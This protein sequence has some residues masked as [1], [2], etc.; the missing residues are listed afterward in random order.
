[1]SVPRKVEFKSLKNRGQYL[2]FTL[3][4]HLDQ[5]LYHATCMGWMAK[6]KPTYYIGFVTRNNFGLEIVEDIK[7]NIAMKDISLKFDNAKLEA[8]VMNK[9]QEELGENRFVSRRFGQASV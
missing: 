4:Y 1:M 9:I 5:D 7:G 6:G 8:I 2:E 3:K